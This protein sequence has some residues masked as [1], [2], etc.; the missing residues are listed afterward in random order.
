MQHSF[1]IMMNSYGGDSPF[2][3]Q[4]MKVTVRLIGLTKEFTLERF[5]D[6]RRRL[7]PTATEGSRRKAEQSSSQSNGSLIKM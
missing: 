7:F 2:A 5:R 6:S 3:V 4:N 1:Y